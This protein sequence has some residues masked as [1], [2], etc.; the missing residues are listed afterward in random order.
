MPVQLLFFILF[1]SAFQSHPQKHIIF[2][3]DSL[4]AGYGVSPDQAFPEVIKHRIDSLH[5]PY[6]VTNAGVSGETTSGGKNR[7]GWV[8]R[9]P[10][11]IFVLE[12]GANDGL[13]GIPVTGTTANLQAIIDSVKARYPSARIVLAGMQVPPSMGSVYATAFRNLFPAL[14][15]KNNTAL[16]PFLLQNVGGIPRLNQHDGIHP[17]AEGHRLVA[18]NVWKVLKPLL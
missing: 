5:L 14:A 11:D 1:F 16:V 4:T 13:R 3:G 8:L 17:T 9:Q 7:I 15:A 10:V 2:F 12:L 6:Q 18:N